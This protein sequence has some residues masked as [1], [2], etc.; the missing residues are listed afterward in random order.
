MLKRSNSDAT[1]TNTSRI[2]HPKGIPLHIL[3]DFR[4]CSF[5]SGNAKFT[6]SANKPISKTV[7]LRTGGS[8]HSIIPSMF[9]RVSHLNSAPVKHLWPRE[10]FYLLLIRYT[11]IFMIG[12]F[13]T[14][15]YDP[16]SCSLKA[17]LY[18]ITSKE[19]CCWAKFI[20][21]YSTEFR[22]LIFF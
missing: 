17:E 20:V 21:L 1:Q 10:A 15:K 13:I 6:A 2:T 8:T 3:P 11:Q 7:I 19:V 16:F 18:L 4:C 9:F 5:F 14:T 22:T 12:F